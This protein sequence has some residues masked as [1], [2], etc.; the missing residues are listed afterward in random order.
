[1]SAHKNKPVGRSSR[2]P[3]KH[4]ILDAELGRLCGIFGSPAARK[5][6]AIADPFLVIDLCAGD[7]VCNT[8]HDSSPAIIR[9][10]LAWAASRGVNVKAVLIEKQSLTFD[11][12]HQSMRPTP[13]WMELIN[14]DARDYRLICKPN[15]A[16][17]VHSDPNHIHDWPISNEL[18]TGLSE[19]TTMLCTLGCNVGGLKQLPRDV[20][21]GWF[22][23]VLECVNCMPFFHDAILI[24]L[25][26]DASQW[27][28]LLRLPCKW[29]AKTVKNIARIGAN[30]TSYKVVMASYIEERDKFE[31]LQKRLFLTAKE[32][33]GW[34]LPI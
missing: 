21:E 28:Y 24:A 2:T 4:W 29:S 18:I 17:F 25:A 3:F 1:M 13:A 15:Q 10:H 12:L 16:V 30:F 7:G 11:M 32:R 6:P 5:V 8:D 34:T 14:G 33:R 26:G 23:H 27:A 31:H 19:T 9:K 22:Q 20:R